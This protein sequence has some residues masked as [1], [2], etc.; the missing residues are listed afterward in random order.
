MSIILT[1]FEPFLG[2]SI[3]PSGELID[4]YSR[5]PKIKTFKLPVSY[6]RTFSPLEK[7]LSSFGYGRH[8]NSEDVMVPTA[9]RPTDLIMLG[10]AGGRKSISL[11][12][13]AMNWQDTEYADEDGEKRL[14]QVIEV[15]GRGSYRSSYPLRDWLQV[16]QSKSDVS[17]EIS[18]SAGAFV[19]NTLS[20]QAAHWLHVNR[21]P[22][23]WIFIHFPYLPEQV[24]GKNPT[25]PTMTLAEM[26]LGLDLVLE[27][28]RSMQS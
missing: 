28:C 15:T 3:N 11:E 4:L 18:H 16:F 13:F 14:E 19:C 25:P 21:W 8:E 7:Y 5:D 23:R 22:L 24:S 1:G 6:S 10:Q 26:K 9:E 12:R 17:F 20:Y 27:Q 2:E